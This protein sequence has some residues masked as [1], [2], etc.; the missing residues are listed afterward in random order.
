MENEH[1]LIKRIINGETELYSYFVER[2]GEKVFALVSQIIYCKEDAEEITQDVFVK[3]YTSLHKYR[4]EC[5]FT[6]W[7]YR[8]AYNHSISAQRKRKKKNEI[9][10]NEL[11]LNRVSID[12][13]EQYIS[14]ERDDEQEELLDDLRLAISW[15]TMEE[16]ALIILF[17]YE[18]KSIHEC[19][20]ILKQSEN[21]IKV[22]LH[23]T[24]TKLSL[25]LYRIKHGNKT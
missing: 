10:V 22:R 7:I 9:A 14:N 12:T 4:A 2:Y 15:L 6:T 25:Y 23:R 17:Y 13:F 5:E 3:A 21:N 19:A 11:E 16:R 18:E 8:I 20:I 24:R 1:K